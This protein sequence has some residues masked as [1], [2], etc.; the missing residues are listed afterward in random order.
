MVNK[1]V[2]RICGICNDYIYGS[3]PKVYVSSNNGRRDYYAHVDCIKEREMT[4]GKY[5][6]SINDAER[7]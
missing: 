2:L 1:T 4:A 7:R 6:P 5:I 3:D